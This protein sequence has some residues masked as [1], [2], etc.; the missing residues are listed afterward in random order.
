MGIP[1]GATLN[2]DIEVVDVS[3]KAPPGPNLFEEIDVDSDG[4]L[5]KEEVEKFFQEKHG[6]GMPDG[7]W[8]NEDKDKNVGSR[9]TN[10]VE[11]KVIL[12]VQRNFKSVSNDMTYVL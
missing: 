1:G 6:N 10:L 4:K 9:G 8:E 7:L 5:T 12:P 11:A 2:F 3:D